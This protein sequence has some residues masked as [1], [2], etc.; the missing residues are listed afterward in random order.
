MALDDFGSGLYL[1]PLSQDPARRLSEDRRRLRRGHG[2]ERP[3]MAPW[4]RP[5]TR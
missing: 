1:V 5:S 4:S 2:R 3:A